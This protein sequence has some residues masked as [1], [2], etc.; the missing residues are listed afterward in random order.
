M[1]MQQETALAEQ[2]LRADAVEPPRAVLRFLRDAAARPVRGGLHSS[3]EQAVGAPPAVAAAASAEAA[4]C[5]G[6]LSPSFF[7]RKMC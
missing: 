5:G 7:K 3:V 4:R 2:S 6:C 1:V